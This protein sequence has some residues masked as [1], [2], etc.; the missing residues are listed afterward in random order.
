[1][2]R[3]HSPDTVSE[4]SRLAVE[5]ESGTVLVESPGGIPIEPAV[6]TVTF[7]Y[8][9]I[10]SEVRAEL[11]TFLRPWDRDR[12]GDAF[13]LSTCLRLE[14]AMPTEKDELEA[15]LEKLFGEVPS[16]GLIR[17]G[18][19]AVTHLFRVAAG[20][21]S[22]IV[23]ELEVWTQFRRALAAFKETGRLP[24]RFIKLLEQAVAT[25]RLAREQIPNGVHSSLATL[26]TELMEDI[27]EVAILGAGLMARTAAETLVQ[28]SP[29]PRVVV[30]ARRP[31][32]V[33]WPGTEAWPFERAEEALATFPAVISATSA[34]QRLVSDEALI[35]IL[36][37][38]G[39][40]LTLVDLAMPPDF[41]P[42]PEAPVRY[43]A[44]DE[45]AGMVADRFVTDDADR[46]VA[47]A[48]AE[49]WR[50]YSN[51][52]EIGPL[53]AQLYASADEV[54]D[55]MVERFSG[56]LTDP[57]DEAVLRQTAHTVARALLA[58]PVGYLH[59]NGS[60]E[61]VASILAT[62]FELEDP[63][64]FSRTDG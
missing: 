24:G 60:P 31:E 46:E 27:S 5:I 39:T 43:V 22:P 44:I 54:V 14:L 36:A 20:L 61:E 41:R 19:E 45:L 34:K 53:I 21:E 16:G 25:G 49:A 18:E 4:T 12:L 7:A 40:R 8:P 9:D 64:D 50:R 23:G 10:P 13:V 30:V 15:R 11:V 28:R 2:S 1:M 35:E 58:G 32:I 37:A 51:H 63:G 26:A 29:A 17:S 56:R 47:G 48:A 59:R 33:D 3:P 62:A 6:S 42:P 57:D 52:R 38:R 55:Q